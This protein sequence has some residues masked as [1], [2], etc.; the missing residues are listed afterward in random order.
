MRITRG[1]RLTELQLLIPPALLVIVG[2][3]TVVLVPT[4]QVNWNW[5]DL[6]MTFVFALLAIAANVVL[7]VFLTR[8]DQ[9]LLPLTVALAGFGLIMTQR[10]QN[11]ALRDIA[12][13]QVIWITV[14]FVVLMVVVATSRIDLMFLKNYKYTWLVIG[15]VLEAAVAVFGKEINGAKLWF[16]FGFF[17][18]QPS[19]VLKVLMVVFLAAYLDDKRDLISSN[20]R[21]GRIPVP[22]I[23]YLLPLLIIVGLALVILTVQKELGAALLFLGVVLIMLYIASGRALYVIVGLIAFAG[24]AFVAYRL[25]QFGYVHARIDG[26]LNPWPTAQDRTYQV[27]QSLFSLANGG[28]LGKGLGYGSPNFIPEVQTDFVFAAIGEE[29][30]MVGAIGLLILYILLVYRGFY[31][32]LHARNGFYQFLAFGLASTLGLQTLII[33]GGVT[34][35]IP[36]TGITLPFIS[37]GGSSIII[38]FF[39]IGILLRISAAD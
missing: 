13:K 35:L 2:M 8:A 36:L 12:T 39:I 29:L 6:W 11:N 7:S 15:I 4:G 5:T 3:L 22:P 23:P 32:A 19:E 18:F 31:I 20:L 25:P 37:Y 28:V 16:D 14:G 26:W 38:N 21:I 34:R 24:G 30:G 1:V 33:I 27:V 10:L 17:S 9:L